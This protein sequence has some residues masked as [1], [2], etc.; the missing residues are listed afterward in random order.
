[1]DRRRKRTLTFSCIQEARFQDAP[2]TL[3]SGRDEATWLLKLI[4]GL[5]LEGASHHCALLT[6][7]NAG[8]THISEGRMLHCGQGYEEM[9]DET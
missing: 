3:C 2:Q 7:I 5:E 1:V 9:K 4:R 8:L 6:T